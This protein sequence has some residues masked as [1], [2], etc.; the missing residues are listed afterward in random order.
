MK[1]LTMLL[2]GVLCAAILVAQAPVVRSIKFTNFE[3]VSLEEI[4]RVFKDKNVKL[5]VERAYDPAEVAAA[6]STLEQLLTEKR[7]TGLSVNVATRDIPP[8]SIE[9]VFSVV[10]R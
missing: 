9:I 4:L 2:A 8:R 10:S 1:L 7:R 5:A 3:P 6:Q